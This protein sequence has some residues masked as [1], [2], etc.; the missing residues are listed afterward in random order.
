MLL[1]PAWLEINLSALA[2]NLHNL[3]SVLSPHQQ[4]IAVIKANAYGHGAIPVSRVALAS[5][6]GRL[7]VA[8]V[9]EAV[10]LR[11]D[12]CAAPILILSAVPRDAA[13]VLV[14]QQI[15]APLTDLEGA[16]ALSRAAQRLGRPA[17]AHLKVDTGLNRLGV[18][19]EEIAAFCTALRD[20]PG[21]EI[22]GIFTHFSSAPDD[23]EATMEQFSL[24]KQ[25]VIEAERVLGHRIAVRHACNSA[26]TVRYPEAWLDAVRP[27]A[28]V[29]GIPRNRGGLYMPEMRPV[30]ALR[31]RLAAVTPVRAGERVGYDL[32]WEAPRDTRLG[33]LP[34]GYSDGWDRRLSNRG[35]VLLHGR[36][37]PIVG[38][39]CMDTTLVDLGP[40]PEAQ[41]DDVAALI[42]EQGEEEIQIHELAETC[43]TVHQEFVSRLGTRLPREYFYEP[44]DTRVRAALAGK[45]ELLSDAPLRYRP[46]SGQHR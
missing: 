44:G 42:G 15:E 21:L 35:H 12:G 8:L 7:A 45:E 43:D 29:Y 20:L 36:R 32:S 40:V 9:Q 46:S 38:R 17:L 23:P 39:V 18:R 6:A 34:L 1:R 27:G 41:V 37:C 28:L 31:A 30:L 25:A 5:G 24:F 4:I 11:Q 2:D 13:P 22:T 19:T 14:E 16:E 33:L 3:K 10:E 26:A